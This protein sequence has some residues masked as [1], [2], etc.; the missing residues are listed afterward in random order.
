ML[1]LFVRILITHRLR[2]DYHKNVFGSIGQDSEVG[3]DQVNS[4]LSIHLFSP[5][6][7]N[8]CFHSQQAGVNYPEFP[9]NSF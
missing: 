2:Y 4:W 3:Q 7:K 8:Q 1:S 9:D 6:F 5:E